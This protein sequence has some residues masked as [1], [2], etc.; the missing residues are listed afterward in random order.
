MLETD[1][2]KKPAKNIKNLNNQRFGRLH[3]LGYAGMAS[4]GKAKNAAWLC[5][6]DCKSLTII[7]GH[8][9]TSGKT[10][11][12]GCLQKELQSARQFIH[13]ES[14]HAGNTTEYRAFQ[15]AKERCQNINGKDYHRYGGK[16]IEFHFDSFEQFL[17][18]MGR[19][20]TS[21]HSIDRF[22][23]KNG[24]YS[25]TNCRWATDE[26]QAR[27][28]NTNRLITAFG[29]TQLLVE[30]VEQSN[31]GRITLSD[32]IKRGWCTECAITVPV[33]GDICPHI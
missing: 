8:G 27:N 9:L 15:A 28:R 16:G 23:D 11:S 7:R 12:C 24:H 4:N 22:P 25:P 14:V 5:R 18:V 21:E 26:Q 33:K 32:R 2:T 1:F 17:E 10:Q 31:I 3:V 20:P 13:G 19:K 29:K 6:C 30:W